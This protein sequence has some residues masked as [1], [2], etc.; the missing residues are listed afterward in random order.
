MQSKRLAAAMAGL[1]LSLLVLGDGL[2]AVAQTDSDS[3]S[4]ELTV[5]STPGVTTALMGG[6]DKI[7]ARISRFEAPV[8]Q[9]VKFGTLAIT[10]RDCVTR[11][12]TDPPENAAFLEIV[13]DRPDAQPVPLFS[14]WM[15]SSSPALSALEHPVY[16]VWVIKCLTG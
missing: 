6:L 15:F 14:G 5:P 7:T 4:A 3:D 1:A 16:D 13:D 11:P 8:G 10:A 2:A 9:T 12:P